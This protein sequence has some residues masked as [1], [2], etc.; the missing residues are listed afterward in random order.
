LRIPI[1]HVTGERFAEAARIDIDRD[2]HALSVQSLAGTENFSTCQL[3]THPP[4]MTLNHFPD[5]QCGL[6]PAL[7]YRRICLQPFEA[8]HWMMNEKDH[9]RAWLGHFFDARHDLVKP[10]MF[11]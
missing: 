7:R 8:A 1:T 10:V 3:H 9:A 6:D 4:R 11:L 5:D 2:Y